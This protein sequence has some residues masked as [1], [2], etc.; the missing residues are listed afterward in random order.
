[1]WRRRRRSKGK[2]DCRIRKEKILVGKEGTKL[3]RT[4]AQAQGII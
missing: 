3:G 2:R 1:L 4:K